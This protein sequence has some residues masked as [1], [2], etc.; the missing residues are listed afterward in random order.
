VS[1]DAPRPRTFGP[2]LWRLLRHDIGRKLTALVFAVALWTLLE[3]EVVDQRSVLLDVVTVATKSD[4]TTRKADAP[5]I[6]LVVPGS[7]LMRGV[8]PERVTLDV[9]GIKDDVRNL[10]LSAIIECDETMLGADSERTI[11]I[12]LDREVFRSAGEP[13]G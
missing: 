9:R 5:A 8:K 7:L 1:A 13:R 11:P 12:T 4:A 10:N 3:S 2:R 6:Y